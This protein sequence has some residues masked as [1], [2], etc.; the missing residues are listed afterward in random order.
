MVVEKLLTHIHD[1]GIIATARK[2]TA[3]VLRGLS[4]RIY[5]SHVEILLERDLFQ[6]M[7]DAGSSNLVVRELRPGDMAAVKECIHLHNVHPE[8]GTQRL[9]YNFRHGYRAA[10]GILD[11]NVIAYGWLVGQGQWHPA[12]YLH[13]IKVGTGELFSCDLFVAPRHRK[14]N[15]AMEFLVRAQLIG[16]ESGFKRIV[17][18]ILETNRRSLWVHHQAGYREI[19]RHR[20]HTLFNYL[21]LC[22]RKVVV[23]NDLWF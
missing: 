14:N 19:G 10:L 6:P 4:Q 23:R 5:R 1:H 2:A 13:D 22:G 12:Q 20:V 16:R 3:V 9:A 7:P 8:Y 11:G 18:S 17:T 15:M 21:M